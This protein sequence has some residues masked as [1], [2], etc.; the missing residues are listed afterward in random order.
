[1]V[2]KIEKLFEERRIYFCS[3]LVEELPEGKRG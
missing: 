1:M 2:M 3:H